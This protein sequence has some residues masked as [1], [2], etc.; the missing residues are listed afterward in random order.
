[1]SLLTVLVAVGIIVYVIGQ[2]LAGSALSG[3]RVVVLPAVLTVI[4]IVNIS[5]HKSHPGSRSDDE[6]WAEIET[7][8]PVRDRRF[9]YP[10]RSWV[11]RHWAPRATRCPPPSRKGS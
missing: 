11:K 7:L 6:L 8:T 2:Q 9:R 1:M 10:A 3:K 4:G 5:G